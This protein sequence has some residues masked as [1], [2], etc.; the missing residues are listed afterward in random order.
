[1]IAI[2][3][4]VNSSLCALRDVGHAN[5]RGITNGHD[6]PRDRYR[7]TPEACK[8]KHLHIIP[9]FLPSDSFIPATMTRAPKRRGN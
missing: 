2:R 5:E 3:F 6:A 8:N 7:C 1:M 4:I 9:K